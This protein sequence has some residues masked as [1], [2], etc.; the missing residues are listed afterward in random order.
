VAAAPQALS[1]FNGVSTTITAGS[2]V[3]VV[4]FATGTTAPTMLGFNTRPTAVNANI[5]SAANYRI[6][7]NAGAGATTSPNTPNASGVGVPFAPGSLVS[8]N[9]NATPDPWFGLS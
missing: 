8:S 7:R 6:A 3:W 2:Y 1:A 5:A 4:Q 9:T